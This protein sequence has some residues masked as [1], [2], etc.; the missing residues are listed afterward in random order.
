MF[1]CEFYKIFKNIYF[2]NVFEGLPLKSNVFTGASFRK[3]LSFYYTQNRQLFYYEGTLSYI[4]LKIS[5]RVNRVIFPNSSELLLLK[6]P[7]RQ[8]YVRGQQQRKV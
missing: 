7:S 3:I 2:A 5:E 1:S 8:K 6:I 4:T